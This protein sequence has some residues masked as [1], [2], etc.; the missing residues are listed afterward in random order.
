M[1][2]A[3]RL[4]KRFL[5]QKGDWFDSLENVWVAERTELSLVKVPLFYF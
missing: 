1:A 5:A 4:E 3:Q 2:M